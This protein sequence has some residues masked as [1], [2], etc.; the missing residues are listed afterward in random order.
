MR[1]VSAIRK[2]AALPSAIEPAVPEMA[3]SAA[4]LIYSTMGV[5]ADHLLGNGQPEQAQALLARLFQVRHNVFSHQLADAAVSDGK[6]VGMLVSASWRTM[7]RLR[8]PTAI[9]VAATGGFST[10]LRLMLRSAP[11]A[12]VG[13]AEDNEYFVAHVAVAPEFQHCGLGTLLMRHAETKARQ[14]G[15]TRLALTVAVDNPG[16][17]LFYRRLGFGVVGTSKFPALEAS[18]GYA[19]FHRMRKSLS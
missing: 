9:Q 8:L 11:L 17:I 10:L 6:P 3:V 5:V 16:A 18:I 15:C 12:G 1:S 2:V 13:E 19:G 4:R 7:E 14:L